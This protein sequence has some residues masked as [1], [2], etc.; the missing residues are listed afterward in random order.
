[1]ST[2]ILFSVANKSVLPSWIA[3]ALF[4]AHA[5]TSTAVRASLTINALCYAL[6]LLKGSSDIPGSNFST[7]KGVLNIFRKGDDY[8]LNA[9]WIHYLCFDLA[10]GAFITRDANQSGGKIP[11]LMVV[12]C[13]FLTLMFGPVG[14]LSYSMV[15]FYF[16]RQFITI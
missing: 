5:H 14:F 8:V 10:M 4:P 1:M 9:C 2:D 11:H 3:L 15:K 13:L 12:P 7:L 6:S 16:T